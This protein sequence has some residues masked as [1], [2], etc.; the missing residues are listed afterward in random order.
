MKI[1]ANNTGLNFQ[2]VFRIQILVKYIVKQNYGFAQQK[3]LINWT[4]THSCSVQSVVKKNDMLVIVV[5]VQT[6]CSKFSSTVDC[7]N[8]Y[9]WNNIT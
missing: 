3:Q 2:I 8:E 7:I 9:M 1:F 6:T 5:S 4:P